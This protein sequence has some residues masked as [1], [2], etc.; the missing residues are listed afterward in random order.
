MMRRFL[1][2]DTGDDFVM[3]NVIDMYDT[4]LQI[5]G[6]SRGRPATRCSPSTWRT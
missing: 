2:E 3:V 5:E 6:V 1:E 4:P